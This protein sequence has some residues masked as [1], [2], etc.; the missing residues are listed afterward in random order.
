MKRS[1]TFKFKFKCFLLNFMQYCVD[2]LAFLAS[3]I[4]FLFYSCGSLILDLVLKFSTEVAED[5]TISIVQNSIVDGKL[6]ELN[7]NTSHII[8]IP[9][10][11]ETRVTTKSLQPITT[12]PTRTTGT[13]KS[14]GLFQFLIVGNCILS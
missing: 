2:G 8:G 3:F 4:N 7:V 1:L 10:I 5:D 6:G 13:P 9:P 11:L 12:M 14:N